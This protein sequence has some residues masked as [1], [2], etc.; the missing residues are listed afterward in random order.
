M[1][2]LHLSKVRDALIDVAKDAGQWVLEVNEKHLKSITK[3]NSKYLLL[4]CY[5]H[6]KLLTHPLTGTE[7]VAKTD[8]A[9]EAFIKKQLSLWYPLVAFMGEES[10]KAGQTIRDDI[11]TFV[12]DPIDSTSNLVHHL[13]DVCV[14]I[15]LVLG[16]QPIIGVVYNPFNDELWAGHRGGGAWTEKGNALAKML[17]LYA[18]PFELDYLNGLS[19]LTGACIGVDWGTDREGPE[20]DLNLKVFTSL[21]R[22]QWT[23]GKF[24]NSLRCVGS[25]AI[26]ICRTAAGQQ[27]MFWEC[28][29]WAWD[30]AAAWCILR[31]AGGVMVD[32][33]VPGNWNPPIDNRRYLAVRPAFAGQREAV[34]EFW[35]VLGDSRSQYGPPSKEGKY[36]EVFSTEDESTEG[37]FTEVGSSE[38][39]F[40]D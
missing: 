9:V 19:R 1:D 15:A 6:A 22:T 37:E 5:I 16:N 26:A 29:A 13:P 23:G 14:S 40:T 18:P 10:Y 36:M 7:F 38:G 31:E 39:E 30:V 3:T 2:K 32:G 24:V 20:F 27:D 17:P 21:A 34:E 35:S 12:V 11:P 28:G 8:K 25:A 33:G 4:K